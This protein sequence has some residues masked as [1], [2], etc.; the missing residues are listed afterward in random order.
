MACSRAEEAVGNDVVVCTID[1]VC[2]S[3]FGALGEGKEAW[4]VARE[5]FALF[6]GGCRG[7]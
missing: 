6:T 3:P 1:G 7:A 4:G 2:A 5:M